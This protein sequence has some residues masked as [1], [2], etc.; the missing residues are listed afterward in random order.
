MTS[1]LPGP[2]LPGYTLCP[3]LASNPQD[4]LILGTVMLLYEL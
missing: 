1:I 2:I 3:G 4:M